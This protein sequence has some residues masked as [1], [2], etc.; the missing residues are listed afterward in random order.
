MT[1]AGVGVGSAASLLAMR[2][3]CEERLGGLDLWTSEPVNIAIS[4]RD[5]WVTVLE[6]WQYEHILEV[7]RGRSLTYYFMSVL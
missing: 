7:L 6:G 1:G 5:F 3:S 2:S 4:K